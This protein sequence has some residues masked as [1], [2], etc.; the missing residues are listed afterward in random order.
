[1]GRSVV[2]VVVAAVHL[3]RASV[4]PS[5]LVVSPP[6]MANF[7][8]LHVSVALHNGTTIDGT[9]VKIDTNKNT[10]HVKSTLN[11]KTLALD[12]SKIA[13][14]STT[15]A[16]APSSSSSSSQ[17]PDVSHLPAP[18][19]K[20][21]NKTNKKSSNNKHHA[22]F[23]NGSGGSQS[24]P[25]PTEDFDFEASARSFDKRRIWEQIRAQDQSDPAALLVSH[26][27]AVAMA[28][29]NSS[30]SSA[31]SCSPRPADLMRKLRNDENVLSPEPEEKDDEEE[32]RR[33][34]TTTTAV[35]PSQP[36]DEIA[37]LKRRLH[38]LES[39]AGLS[40]QPVEST[41]AQDDN[42]NQLTLNCTILATPTGPT[43]FTLLSSLEETDNKIRFKPSED[44]ANL[45]EKYKREMGLRLDNGSARVF[46]QRFV[47]ARS[48]GG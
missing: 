46:L 10:L 34:E 3:A 9:I 25:V 20:K 21:T 16:P 5:F 39:L 43:S 40:L 26:N 38:I 4:S 29:G 6:T 48:E 45:P 8:G 33:Q 13:S 47:A 41:S 31:A 30:S 22:A 35:T 12:R 2:P 1:M 37:I 19:R 14:L 44:D 32:K 11:G 23:D 7:I 15:A 42:N 17:P 28:A 24:A 27:R 36:T 18:T